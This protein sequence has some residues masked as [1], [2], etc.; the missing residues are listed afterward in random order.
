MNRLRAFAAMAAVSAAASAVAVTDSASASAAVARPAAVH[1]NGWLGTCYP[2]H[3]D[4]TFGG[5]CDGNGPSSYYAF[6]ECRD[7][8]QVSGV[9]RWDGNRY[10]SY[11]YCSGHGGLYDPNSSYTFIFLPNG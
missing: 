4:N 7:G 5:W 2:W 3:D 6:A 10:G 8:A 1:A 9:I 11:A